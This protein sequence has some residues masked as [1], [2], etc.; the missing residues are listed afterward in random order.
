MAFPPVAIFIGGS[1]LEGYTS[2]TLR[3]SKEE[4]TGS[5]NVDLFFNYMP[6]SPVVVDA[7]IAKEFLVYIGGQLAF[8]GT[9]D[10]RNG[11]SVSNGVQRRNARTGRFQSGKTSGSDRSASIGPNGYSVSLSARGKTKAAV[12]SSHQ[13]KTTNMLKTTSK[14]ALEELLKPFNIQLEWLG[15][16]VDLDKVRFRDGAKVLEEIRRIATENG[17]YI[18]ET[19]DGR[20]RVTDDV[21][22]GQGDPLVLGQNILSFSATQSES[23]AQSEI[24][25]KGQRIEKGKWGEEAI[26]QNTVTVFN[27]SWVPTFSPIVVQ[28]YGNGTVEA[29]ERRARFEANK[30][31]SRSKQLQV[32]VFH[33]QAQGAPWDVGN[34]HYV[35]VPP[36]GIFDMFECTE[37]EYHVSAEGELTTS[38]T[39][40]PPPSGQKSASGLD[41]FEGTEQSIQGVSQQAARGV[42]VAQGNYPFPWS[43]PTIKKIQ[44][45]AAVGIVAALAGVTG[46]DIIAQQGAP[47]SPP[48]TLP[49]EFDT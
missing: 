18:Y 1:Q 32:D 4:L 22:T 44:Q 13:H 39:L 25:V 43:G 3:R 26:L 42:T 2:M 29:L 15:T 9:I 20:L 14:K 49:V 46:L 45:P 17:Y 5:C 36:E 28:H 8:N 30:R 19:R 40:S 23:Q 10:T 31:S 37:L 12:D 48:M 11:D 41:V 6:E 27:D 47:Y 33:V 16:D 38:L 7:A 34:L 24:T 35:E 21:G